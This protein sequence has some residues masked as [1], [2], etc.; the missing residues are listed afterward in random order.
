[1]VIGS[2][3]QKSIAIKHGILPRVLTLLGDAQL[4]EEARREACVVLGSLVKGTE[5]NV[6]AVVDACSVPVLVSGKLLTTL[7]INWITLC[8]K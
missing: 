6:S 8:L 1:M 3:R 4:S 7:N 5:E 2:N